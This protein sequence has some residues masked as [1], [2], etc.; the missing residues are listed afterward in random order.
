[1]TS[2]SLLKLDA[3]ACVPV[4]FT[5]FFHSSYAVEHMQVADS[6]I[7]IILNLGADA[8]KDGEQIVLHLFRFCVVTFLTENVWPETF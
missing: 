3:Q 2:F 6:E 1:M 5:I 8:F 4:D 7:F